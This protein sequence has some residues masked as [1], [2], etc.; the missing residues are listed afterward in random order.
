MMLMPILKGVADIRSY[1]GSVAWFHTFIPKFAEITEPL[2]KLIRL[3]AK[4]EWGDVQVRAIQ[5][6]REAIHSAP[7]LY[8]FDPEKPTEVFTDASA[9]AIGGWIGQ[10]HNGEI[11]PIA[12]WSR[13]MTAH[14]LNYPT[15]EKELLALVS[16]LEKHNYWLR[17]T[18][19]TAFTDHESIKFLNTQPEL[20]RRQARW[21]L[22]LSEYDCLIRYIKGGENKLADLLSR[23]VHVQ[24]LC[25]N[26]KESLGKEALLEIEA[27]AKK[28]LKITRKVTAK[29]ESLK[30]KI[31]LGS[32]TDAFWNVLETQ[33]QANRDQFK[34]FSKRGGLWF[35]QFQR[36]YIP[37]AQRQGILEKYHDLPS[38]GHQG[39][40]LTL[41]LISRRYYW[42]GL[43]RDVE[44]WVR[45]CYTCQ[46]HYPAVKPLA[47]YLNPLP[48]PTERF[49]DI[50]MDFC[51]LGKSRHS[52]NDSAL[53]IIDRLTKFVKVLPCQ[54]KISAEKTGRLFLEHWILKGFGTP[55]SIISDMD[56][57]FLSQFWKSM[58]LGLKVSHSTATA[59]HQQT[60]GQA[61]NAV[62]VVKRILG[63]LQTDGN[64][65]AHIANCEHA[66]NNS[67]SHSTGFSPYFLVF[68]SN[69]RDW[70]MED[71]DPD[72]PFGRRSR[73]Y[74]EEI[75]L[76]VSE[77]QIQMQD[78][79]KLQKYYYDLKR[80]RPPVYKVD[81]QV[82]L[83]GEDISWPSTASSKMETQK[84]IGP[85]KVLEV[86]G[87][88][89][90]LELT[91]SLRRLQSNKFHVDKLL[92]YWEPNF[93]F[94]G[95]VT[96]P[97]PPPIKSAVG[98]LYEIRKIHDAKVKGGSSRQWVEYLV[99][100]KGYP[101]AEKDWI[102]YRQEDQLSSNPW[103]AEEISMLKR[104]DP[105][106]F[107][108]ASKVH[109]RKKRKR[110]D[111][112]VEG[113]ERSRGILGEV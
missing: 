23:S 75:R 108:A 100:W 14:E 111:A 79:Q 102:A 49:K 51:F 62:K 40:G 33:T 90:T 107:A 113:D 82:L 19:F 31:L 54:T 55:Q 52:T 45:S 27:Q 5:Q 57:L 98:A 96:D 84:W 38:A 16:M 36:V 4:W 105:E 70:G 99:S 32:Q 10:R 35:Y 39:N 73:S 104:F 18:P 29:P 81:D 87:L 8:Y 20:S 80:A 61:E 6:L 72:E 60:D 69:P 64:W 106:L 83:N 48:I 78:A 15:H 74:I 1:L 91:D 77:A 37:E 76:A 7:T 94:S 28:R 2:S 24:T 97:R 110:T 34:L 71:I 89:C 56:S 47:G 17:S 109:P 93:Y 26:C 25:T 65:E 13:K 68:G 53:I 41:E 101:E 11:R 86:E 95:R 67:I 12:Y 9:F 103:T 30:K 43:T 58:C 21:I 3:N 44:R 88:N 50:A 46:T 22:L 92:P 85:M 42:P 66:I 63:K 59:R 112:R